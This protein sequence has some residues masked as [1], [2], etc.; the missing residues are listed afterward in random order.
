MVVGQVVLLNGVSSSG[1]SSIS[2]ELQEMLPTP[3][4]R[5]GIDTFSPM[6][7]ERLVAFDPPAGHPAELGMSVETCD[8]PSGPS[9][10]LH[11]GEVFY[12]LIRGMHR[13]LAAMAR[14]GNDI[15]FDDVIYDPAYFESY[16]EAFEGVSVWFVGVKIPLHVVEQRERQ[17]GNRAIGHARGHFDLVHRHGPY[18]I[19]VDTEAYSD[20]ECAEQII[21]AM[22][23]LGE[24]RAF[25]ASRSQLRI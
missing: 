22:N 23:R 13:A 8:G 10:V 25:A 24:P 3:F 19:E 7:P 9:L 20:R 12:R 5:A 15:I 16:L 21:E 17:R 6:I 18:D 11:P 4:L 14:E 2:A 1:K